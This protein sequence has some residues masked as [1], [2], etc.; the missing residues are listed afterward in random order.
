MSLTSMKNIGKTIAAKLESVGIDSKESLCQIGPEEAF[1]RLK[2][3]YSNTCLVTLYVLEGAVTN[4]DYNKLPESRK[5]E[6]KQY[7]D[8]LKSQP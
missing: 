5:Q 6:L 7:S 1:S 3:K 2:K 8:S 4:Q